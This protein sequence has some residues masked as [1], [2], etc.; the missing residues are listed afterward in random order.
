[1]IPGDC[2]WLHVL[3]GDKDRYVTALAHVEGYMGDSLIDAFPLDGHGWEIFHL[4]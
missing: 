1:M 4:R 3:S 2:Y